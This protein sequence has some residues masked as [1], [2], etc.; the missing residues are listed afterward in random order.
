M[1]NS[2]II[3]GAQVA[4][5]DLGE[6]P[7]MPEYPKRYWLHFP[8]YSGFDEYWRSNFPDNFEGY[9]A[10]SESFVPEPSTVCGQNEFRKIA[11]DIGALLSHTDLPFIPLADDGARAVAESEIAFAGV[12]PEGYGAGHVEF[13]PL[14]YHSYIS[15]KPAGPHSTLIGAAYLAIADALG[16]NRARLSIERG[17]WGLAAGMYRATFP[18]RDLP[19]DIT[20]D[21]SVE[22]SLSFRHDIS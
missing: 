1:T 5:R 9:Q 20:C 4:L 21:H 10:A 3:N 22:S 2:A 16:E 17:C 13:S 15:T 6:N 7:D 19:Q 12:A 8:D 14:P 11:A 18:K